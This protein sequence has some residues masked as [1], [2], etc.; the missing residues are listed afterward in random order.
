MSKLKFTTAFKWEIKLIN[1]L[2]H[3]SSKKLLLEIFLVW[4]SNHCHQPEAESQHH[5]T[6]EV[7]FS[8]KYENK[9]NVLIRQIWQSPSDHQELLQ[10]IWFLQSQDDGFESKSRL[11]WIYFKFC[12]KY[13]VTSVPL[14]EGGEFFL[15]KLFVF[16]FMG[17]CLFVFLSPLFLLFCLVC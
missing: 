6:I 15:K 17:V 1:L 5:S 4:I 7:R 13:Q 8:G 3:S 12:P 16:C 10:I 14:K 2:F 9:E 11:S